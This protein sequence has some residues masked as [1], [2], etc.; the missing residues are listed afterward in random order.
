VP[1]FECKFEEVT[2]EA[3]PETI[4]PEKA[5]A[6]R[7]A[8]FNRISRACNPFRTIEL[9]RRAACTAVTT[10]IAR[11]KLFARW[12]PECQLRPDCWSA[13]PDTRQ[14]DESVAQLLSLRLE[15]VSI[16]LMEIDEGSR[17][18]LEVLTGARATRFGVAGG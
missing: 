14:W 15:H 2:L 12:L 16:Y 11:P 18:G 17:L 1:A 13:A 8:G 4:I 9:K 7:K 6:W 3:D 5:A 10:S